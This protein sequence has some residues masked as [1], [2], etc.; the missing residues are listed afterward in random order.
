MKQYRVS[1]GLEQLFPFCCCLFLSLLWAYA[2]TIIMPSVVK[3]QN[4]TSRC[5]MPTS[6]FPKFFTL[7]QVFQIRSVMF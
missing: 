5:D 4:L 3:K 1:T 2:L 7:I 6:K